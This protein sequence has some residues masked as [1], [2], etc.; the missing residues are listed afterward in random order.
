M[1]R[2]NGYDKLK[3]SPF[4]SL[5][6]HWKFL[7]VND[8]KPP[9]TSPE[10]LYDGLRKKGR[11]VIDG[12]LASPSR[13]DGWRPRLYY[14][15]TP[16]ICPLI[17]YGPIEGISWRNGSTPRSEEHTSELQSR[18]NLVCRLLLEKKKKKKNKTRRKTK[19]KEEQTS[20]R[21]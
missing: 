6:D 3:L 16:S 19:N 18:E 9:T 2:N 8:R 15:Q 12:G 4:F 14:C 11:K 17:R 13:R 1:K 21:A 10:A 20:R 5:I 7:F